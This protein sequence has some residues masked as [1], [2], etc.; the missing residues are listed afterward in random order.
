MLNCEVL[1]HMMNCGIES[2]LGKASSLN[3]TF[4][5]LLCIHMNLYEFRHSEVIFYL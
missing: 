3:K 2:C 1:L 5:A 4:T